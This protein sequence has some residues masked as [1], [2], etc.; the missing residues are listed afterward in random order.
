M[1]RKTLDLFIVLMFLFACAPAPRIVPTSAV[2]PPANTAIVSTQIPFATPS[3]DSPRWVLY[4]RALSFI[5]L[6]P[7]GKTLPDMSRDH[8]LCEWEIWGQKENEVYVWALCQVDNTIG[9]ATSTPAVIHLGED[10][11]ILEIEMPNEGF[12]NLQELF[13]EDVL[14][15]IEN[16]K[17]PAKEAWDRIQ[18]RRKNPSILPLI[19]EREV[20]LP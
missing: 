19:V 11:A 20:P 7:P 13:P 9:T 1:R 3:E 8:G 6:G 15:K 4:E 2:L 10:G 18:M 12:G 14:A 17:F 5:L 16:N